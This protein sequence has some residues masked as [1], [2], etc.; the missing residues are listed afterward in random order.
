MLL[1]LTD[2]M[3][4][5]GLSK[6]TWECVGPSC[7]CPVVVQVTRVDSAKKW[8]KVGRGDAELMERI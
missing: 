4:E 3:T 5:S 8:E 6:A 7:F 1:D 2:S